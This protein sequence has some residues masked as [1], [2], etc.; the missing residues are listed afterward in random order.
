ML[1][2][3]F[4]DECLSRARTFAWF[5]KIME[6]QTSADDNPRSGR[7]STRRNNHS[8]TR[9]RE[10]IHANRRLTVREISAEAFIS[11]GTCEAILTEN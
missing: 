9:V 8:V 7:P 11:Y 4:G 5:K 6:G 2:T 1:K 3:A 10:L